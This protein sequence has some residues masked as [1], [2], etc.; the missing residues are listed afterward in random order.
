MSFDIS[1]LNDNKGIPPL[2]EWELTDSSNRYDK[3]LAAPSDDELQV[4]WSI[5]AGVAWVAGIFTLVVFLGV[6][7]SREARKHSFNVYLIGLMIP[8]IGFSLLCGTTCFLNAWNGNYWSHTMCNFQQWYC[9]WGIGSNCWLNAVVTRELHKLLQ[10]NRQG[11]RYILPAPRTVVHQALAVYVYCGFLGT[12][13]LIDKNAFPFYSVQVSGLACIPMVANVESSL[14]FWLCF[15]PLFSL[16][17]ILYVIYVTFDIWRRQLLPP[18]GRRRLLALYFGRIV[19]IFLLFWGPFFF[20]T[21]LLAAVVPAWVRVV[22][23]TL[24]H[25]QGP[26]SAGVTLLKPD[27][28]LAVQ[29]FTMCRFS[30]QQ[31]HGIGA[32][33]RYPGAASADDDS[34][35][36]KQASH[37][38]YPLFPSPSHAIEKAKPDEEENAAEQSMKGVP[39]T[40]D[41]FRSEQTFICWPDDDGV[42]TDAEERDEDDEEASQASS[43][44]SSIATYQHGVQERQ[45]L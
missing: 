26:L 11:R 41:Y 34:S 22:G 25:L 32:S 17:P 43:T 2:R 7:S 29:R 6:I 40:S 8:D 18:S 5:W 15:M 9:V 31:H 27:I 38:G 12:W 10:S 45:D 36:I 16:I 28:R 39:S 4:Y 44:P 1:T 35:S 33:E 20:C 37:W 21:Y 23:G 14:F 13:G 24:S 30:D 3:S 19:F 42:Y